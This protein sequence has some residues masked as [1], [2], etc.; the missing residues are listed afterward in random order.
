MTFSHTRHRSLGP[1]L[2]PVYRQSACRW[3]FKLSPGSGLPLL[4]TRP[5]DI[6]PAE[7]RLSPATSTEFYC[8]MTEAHRCEL[9]AQGC[10]TALSHWEWN[11]RLIDHKSNALLMCLVSPSVSS[12]K[13]HISHYAEVIFL[14]V[15]SVVCHLRSPVSIMSRLLRSPRLASLQGC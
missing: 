1:Q 2:I 3:L 10:Y 13:F 4:S 11:P 7:E 9:L 12:V 6:F 8:L 5:A 14:C 15:V